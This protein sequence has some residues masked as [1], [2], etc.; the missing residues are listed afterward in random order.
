MIFRTVLIILTILIILTPFFGL[1]GGM[2]DLV[3]QLFAA[4]VFVLI[5]ATPKKKEEKK[6]E[7]S[8]Y[9]DVAGIE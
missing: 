5:L 3:M 2:E 7:A 4:C 1:P 9:S 8:P 6:E